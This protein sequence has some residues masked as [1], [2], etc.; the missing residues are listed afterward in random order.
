MLGLD[1]L[2]VNRTGMSQDA[3][4]LLEA[5]RVGHDEA[6]PGQQRHEARVRL[7][8]DQAEPIVEQVAEPKLLDAAFSVAPAGMMIGI[9]RL[10]TWSTSRV[11]VK[12]PRFVASRTGE[13]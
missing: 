8:L 11:S 10:A 5:A 3:A 2:A 12:A 6:G 7:L 13:A 9:S 1:G 4:L